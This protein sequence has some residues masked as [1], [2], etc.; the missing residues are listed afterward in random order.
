MNCAS[1]YLTDGEILV[2]L[3]CVRCAMS[4]DFLV[5]THSDSLKSLLIDL[6]FVSQAI[7]HQ[8]LEKF[9]TLEIAL[10]KDYNKFVGR[11]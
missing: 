8:L 7:K 1:I 10:S 11:Y 5:S 6:G 9:V 2:L 4:R 3:K